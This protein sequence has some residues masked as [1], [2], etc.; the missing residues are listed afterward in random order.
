[1]GFPAVAEE[2]EMHDSGPVWPTYVPVRIHTSCPPA[3]IVT[4]GRGVPASRVTLGAIGCTAELLSH[5]KSPT[6]S[7]AGTIRNNIFITLTAE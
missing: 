2:G 6:M 4:G 1:M 7:I 5:A 3:L